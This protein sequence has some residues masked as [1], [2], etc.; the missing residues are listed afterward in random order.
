MLEVGCLQLLLLFFDPLRSYL[1]QAQLLVRR[2][3][4]G[5]SI[6]NERFVLFL[7]SFVYVSQC[8][9]RRVHRGVLDGVQLDWSALRRHILAPRLGL[10][11]SN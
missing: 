3:C 5:R 2:W 8:L 7:L 10:I 4:E 11:T 1:L 6:L 9:F